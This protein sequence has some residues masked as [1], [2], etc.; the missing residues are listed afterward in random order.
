MKKLNNQGDI[1]NQNIT[2]NAPNPNANK[3]PNLKINPNVLNG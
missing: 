1:A 3:N 2:K